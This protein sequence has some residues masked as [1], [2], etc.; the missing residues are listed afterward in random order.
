MFVLL[1]KTFEECRAC[2]KDNFVRLNLFV[3]A[4]YSD[5]IEV[6]IISQLLEG[7]ADIRLEIIP[8]EAEFFS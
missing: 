3:L 2:P 8:A 7:A 4:G 5:I 1:Q 6:A